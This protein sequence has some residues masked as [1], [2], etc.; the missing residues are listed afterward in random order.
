Q[1]LCRTTLQPA[2]RARDTERCEAETGRRNGNVDSTSQ[3]QFTHDYG[4]RGDHR[5]IEEPHRTLLAGDERPRNGGFANGLGNQRPDTPATKCGTKL[6]KKKT[7][8]KKYA[9]TSYQLIEPPRIAGHGP[10]L[11]QGGLSSTRQL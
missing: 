11:Y 3:L 5:Q 1:R 8:P 2:G 4:Q 9:A 7:P 6:A 10:T